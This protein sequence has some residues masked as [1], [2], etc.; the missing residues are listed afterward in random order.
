M[1][2]IVVHI[3]RSSVGMI[4]EAEM[5][6]R[7]MCWCWHRAHCEPECPHH[8]EVHTTAG[9]VLIPAAGPSW[10]IDHR[11]GRHPAPT[12]LG[13]CGRWCSTQWRRG[14]LFQWKRGLDS[15]LCQCVRSI[16]TKTKQNAALL[17]VSNT[18][19][20]LCEDV[21]RVKG[22][23]KQSS[24]AH[25]SNQAGTRSVNCCNL[26]QRP[27]QPHKSYPV[28]TR[29]TAWRHHCLPSYCPHNESRKNIHQGEALMTICICY[30]DIN[31][32][33]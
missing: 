22:P 13:S 7:M 9:D 27:Q 2:N 23:G 31:I 33:I 21:V 32:Y 14:N 24:A 3:S 8:Q 17:L 18:W 30:V 16:S 19:P 10:T 4:L 11:Q 6:M 1:L 25:N 29:C 20:G 26:P 12:T 15:P 5:M 28:Y